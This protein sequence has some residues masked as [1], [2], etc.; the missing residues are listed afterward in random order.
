M[1]K[2]IV[3][4]TKKILSIAKKEREDIVILGAFGCGA[5]RNPPWIVAEAMKEAIKEFEYDFKTIEFAIYC[6]TN[7]TLNYDVF[8]EVFGV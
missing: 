8:K 7:N 3:K 2:I 6:P 5:F 4:R 1:K